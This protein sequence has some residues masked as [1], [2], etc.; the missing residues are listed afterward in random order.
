MRAA[1]A[2]KVLTQ[3]LLADVEAS[4]VAAHPSPPDALACLAP[5]D[6]VRGVAA[7][8]IVVGH[9]LT[10]FVPRA[11][12]NAVWPVFSLE[13]LSAVT[14]FFV[15][16]GFTLTRVYASSSFVSST[17]RRSFAVRRATRLLPLYVAGLA[18]GLAPFVTDS[19]PWTGKLSSAIAALTLTQSL[20]L[21]RATGWD[22]VLWTVSA[23][24]LCSAS[25]LPALPRLRRLTLAQLRWALFTCALASSTTLRLFLRTFGIQYSWIFHYGVVFRLPHFYAGV[26]AALLTSTPSDEHPIIP[27]GYFTRPT[28]ITEVCSTLL[29]ANVVCCG[30]FTPAK[31]LW[32]FVWMYVAEFD[33]LLLQTM[34]VAALCDP[35]CRG[36]TRAILASRPLRA[37]GGVSYALYFLHFPTLQ[38]VSWIVERRIVPGVPGFG[39]GTWYCFDASAIAPLVVTC[40]VVAAAATRFVDPPGRKFVARCWAPQHA[41]GEATGSA[42]SAPGDASLSPPIILKNGVASEGGLER[43]EVDEQ[44]EAL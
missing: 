20:V 6:G 11:R 18:L 23:L 42:A 14:L 26:C 7:L 9:L 16:S 43:A 38:I 30:V 44:A 24:A 40:L 19:Q 10:F 8:F 37:L 32:W 15:V 25:L 13:F 22:G 17:E 41:R 4:S 33:L 12:A 31:P 2:E 3:P 21:W 39:L 28:L 36:P 1:A 5:L 29:L 34:W 27:R 35:R